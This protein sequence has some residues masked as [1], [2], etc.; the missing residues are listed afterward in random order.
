MFC[1]GLK[2]CPFSEIQPQ[3][4][5]ILCVVYSGP[6]A[7]LIFNFNSSTGTKMQRVCIVNNTQFVFGET[8]TNE[9]AKLRI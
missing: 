1:P 3:L 8:I 2:L 4:V 5:I 6:E 7:G 9:S